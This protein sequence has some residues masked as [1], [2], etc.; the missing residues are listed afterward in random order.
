GLGGPPAALP[1][2]GRGRFPAAAGTPIPLADL[3][4]PATLRVLGQELV[5]PDLGRC[6]AACAFVVE[7]SPSRAVATLSR[8]LSAAPPAN[9]RLLVTALDRVLRVTPVASTEAGRG[10]EAPLAARE[11][12]ETIG[13][14][15][16][17]QAYARLLGAAAAETEWRRVLDDATHDE[18]EAVRVAA[19]AALCRLE[20]GGDLEAVLVAALDSDDA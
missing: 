16:L 2:G 12:L 7:A 5:S 19:V 11:G 6:R 1:R 13:R 15:N 9:R 20:P 17:V 10:V 3:L 8:A 4:D 14:A 18:R